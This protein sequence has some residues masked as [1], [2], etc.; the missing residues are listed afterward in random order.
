M[1]KRR[2]EMQELYKE[3]RHMFLRMCDRVNLTC[4]VYHSPI[5]YDSDIHHK[6]GRSMDDYENEEARKMDIPLLIDPQ[7]F[8]AV[9]RRGHQ[10]I[11]L[12]PEEAKE[13]GWSLPR[14]R[15]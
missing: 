7:N 10:Y 8:L 6:R 14:L 12:H 9:S 13:K 3:A 1:S 2:E 11:E 4:P 15:N 5:T